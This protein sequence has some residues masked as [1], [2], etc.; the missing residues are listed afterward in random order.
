MNPNQGKLITTENFYI[1][2]LIDN[3]P[4]LLLLRRLRDESHRFGVNYH[5][6]LKNKQQL[7]S[8]LLEINQLGP[9]TYQKLIKY[10]KTVNNIS[11]AEE[12][13]LERVVS[14]KLAKNIYNHFQNKK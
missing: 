13:E 3:R 2:E 11:Q 8:P 7:K 14:K 10:F 9:I 6:L 5:R 12:H 1:I 4:G